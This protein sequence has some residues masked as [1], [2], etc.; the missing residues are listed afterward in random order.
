MQPTPMIKTI[1]GTGTFNPHR[2]TPP[3]EDVDRILRWAFDR[4]L[5]SE[6]LEIRDAAA[7]VDVV[8]L[9]P[10][11]TGRRILARLS[12]LGRVRKVSIS[13]FE[14]R[15]SDPRTAES[16]LEELVISLVHKPLAGSRTRLA[17]RSFVLLA[18]DAVN[19][20]LGDGRWAS[21]WCIMSVLMEELQSKIV[22]LD[23]TGVGRLHREVE[24]FV[25]SGR[26]LSN[27]EAHQRKKAIESF[28]QMA[29][30]AA[31]NGASLEDLEEALKEEVVRATLES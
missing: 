15:H 12:V 19:P 25:S 31:K 4:E 8:R 28:R 6:L 24:G 5:R 13:P 2:P 20:K 1:P 7:G 29:C 14:G 16:I 9:E 21:Q 26:H 23:T 27:Y 18:Q 30:H 11:P 17:K 22:R 3:S 10:N